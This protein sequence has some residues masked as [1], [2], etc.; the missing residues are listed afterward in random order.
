MARSPVGPLVGTLYA[1][2]PLRDTEGRTGSVYLSLGECP[3]AR[4]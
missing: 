1:L 3:V 2:S 4:Y